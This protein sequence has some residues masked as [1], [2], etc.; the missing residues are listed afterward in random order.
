MAGKAP[1]KYKDVLEL[2]VSASTVEVLL[3]AYF[4]GSSILGSAA[5]GYQS[6]FSEKGPFHGLRRKPDS[7]V[8]TDEN[9]LK[10]F[11]P[12]M[13]EAKVKGASVSCRTADELAAGISTIIQ[14]I[15]AYCTDL[16]NALSKHQKNV[17]LVYKDIINIRDNYMHFAEFNELP[18][19][20]FEESSDAEL[21]IVRHNMNLN[22]FD[23]LG[24]LN[25]NSY[26]RA[27]TEGIVFVDYP[28]NILGTGARSMLRQLRENEW[29]SYE[30]AS[31]GLAIL[32]QQ[33]LNAATH[34]ITQRIKHIQY[35]KHLAVVDLDEL[36]RKNN[37][38]IIKIEKLKAE[39]KDDRYINFLEYVRGEE[40]KKKKNKEMC[41]SVESRID[42]AEYFLANLQK[43][44]ESNK[45]LV[46]K[47][48]KRGNF[49]IENKNSKLNP[50]TLAKLIL[51]GNDF[52]GGILSIF[53]YAERVKITGVVELPQDVADQI[54]NAA[55]LVA[56]TKAN[57]EKLVNAANAEKETFKGAT[58]VYHYENNNLRTENA[59]YK[60]KEQ[61][62]EQE[63]AELEKKNAEL[64]KEKK[65]LEQ[66]LKSQP[67]QIQKEKRYN[68]ADETKKG[69][70][71]ERISGYLNK[72][73][74]EIVEGCE[75][76][77]SEI[78]PKPKV[79]EF[80]PRRQERH[81]EQNRHNKYERQNRNNTH[82]K[83]VSLNKELFSLYTSCRTNLD[84]RNNPR[85]FCEKAE[86][87]YQSN[88]NDFIAITDALTPFFRV[89]LKDLYNA[90][91]M[92]MDNVSAK[93][94]PIVVAEIKKRNPG[95]TKGPKPLVKEIAKMVC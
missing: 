44:M 24:T 38:N 50:A 59:K 92:I 47:D 57:A 70:L 45:A 91:S 12:E 58:K 10:M 95:K 68:A 9:I 75:S 46:L 65:T 52:E 77:I 27:P 69:G 80:E 31:K 49:F 83:Y 15:I 60:S 82:K 42:S 87:K 11:F 19:E 53:D 64:E 55:R 41:D 71:F 36:A 88:I 56:A 51:R 23:D 66:K 16:G 39:F 63:K 35:S 84:S 48:S 8:L 93:D 30:E 1:D 25:D 40:D 5:R 26:K 21:K 85:E 28:K 73:P 2:N 89:D 76:F 94:I 32:K 78:R 20:V 67:R 33:A 3:T 4:E 6:L 17:D 22:F 18:P 14:P 54:E 13:P 61:K 43:C 90:T 7:E 86:S 79:I 29:K 74:S 37:E 62:Y 72:T 34:D 81:E